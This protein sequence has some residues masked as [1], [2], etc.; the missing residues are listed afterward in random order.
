MCSWVVGRDSGAN[1]IK[2][3]CVYNTFGVINISCQVVIDGCF[4]MSR[5]N[6]CL[7][8]AEC[9]LRQC[10]SNRLTDFWSRHLCFD[11]LP[12]TLQFKIPKPWHGAKLL[13]FT[14]DCRCS[15]ILGHAGRKELPYS[16]LPNEY[17]LVCC[18]YMHTVLLKKLK[19]EVRYV[20]WIVGFF[21]HTGVQW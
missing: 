11:N 13:S 20:Q 17:W 10:L 8:A 14:F 21:H 7:A 9:L 18:F 16:Y 12:L 15:F 1:H 6:K 19:T 4:W 2:T 5:Q 3:S